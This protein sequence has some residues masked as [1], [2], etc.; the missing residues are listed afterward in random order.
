MRWGN[1]P[2]LPEVETLRRGLEAG[3]RGRRITDTVIA[4]AKV[5]KE[6]PESVFR[7]RV[8][9]RRIEGINR[10]GKY[11]LVPLGP[12]EMPKSA[13]TGIPPVLLCIHLKMRGQLRLQKANDP[14]GPYH[15]VS[16]FLDAEDVLRFY[17]MWTWGEIRALTMDEAATLP[18][19]AEMG[20]EPLEAGWNGAVLKQRLG[21]RK[22]PIK[23]LLLDQKTVAGVGNIY[24][25]ESLFRA[26]GGDDSGGLDRSGQR[27]WNYLRRVYGFRRGGGAVQSSR[28]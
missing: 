15:C 8:I 3:I 7:E 12:E 17:D 25:D 13:L 19:L 16:L 21:K 11:L 2:E 5:L 10:R 24:A 23:P 18:L 6:Q 28:L 1:L 20:P 9:G 26:A 27:R 22:G 4:N 14:I